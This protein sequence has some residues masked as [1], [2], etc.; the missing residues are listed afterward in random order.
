MTL[1]NRKDRLRRNLGQEA[2]A[3]DPRFTT[4]AFDGPA[5]AEL[6]AATVLPERMIKAVLLS[7]VE[8]FSKPENEG[9]LREL[10]AHLF[11]PTVGSEERETYI[12]RFRSDPP[13]VFLGYPRLTGRWPCYSILLADEEEADPSILD[14][15][16]GAT[17]DGETPP[18]DGDRE[19]HG[20][21][22]DQ[23]FALWVMAQ[24]PD[25]AVYLYHFAKLVLFAAKDAL[26]QVGIIDPTYSGGEL[27]PEEAQFLPEEV[28]SRVLTIKCSTIQTVPKVLQ[29]RDGR[30]LRVTGIFGSDV[31]VDGQRGGVCA[32]PG[33]SDGEE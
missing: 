32:Q 21:F 28:F 17:L 3:T 29:Y 14:K 2:V 16:V 30:R 4:P 23:R 13:E 6:R 7:E 33:V 12:A 5:L 22:W 9:D 11:D 8:R 10:Y 31:V 26:E 1:G 15:Y 24:H 25:E 27:T 18:G 19:Y 20:A